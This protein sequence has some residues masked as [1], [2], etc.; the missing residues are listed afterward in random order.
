MARIRTV[1]PDFWVSEQVMNVTRDA[2]LMFIGLWNFCDDAGNHPASH[3]AIKARVFPG[4]TDIEIHNLQ[5]W[6]G[7][8]LGEGLVAEYEAGGHAYWHVTGWHHQ[9]IEKP[10]EPRYP[11]FP[12]DSPTTPGGFP[13]GSGNGTGALRLDRR[14][15][16]GSGRDSRGE[17]TARGARLPLAWEPSEDL[18]AWGATERPDLDAART[19][20]EF[21]DY[22]QAKPGQGGRKLDWDA[23]YRNWVR[24]ERGHYGNGRAGADIAHATVPGPQ[25]PDPA[26]QKIEADRLKA[27]PMPEAVR[28]KL[29][30]IHRRNP[31]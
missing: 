26:L 4:D 8:L 2:R 28:V 23:T 9:R 10:T 19:L 31:P 15:K 25:G 3:V 30:A 13:D 16:E 21:R 11:L 20:A 12:D 29:A 5:E 22:W 1:K 24:N 18:K 17:R 14:G 6:M 27:V 7:E